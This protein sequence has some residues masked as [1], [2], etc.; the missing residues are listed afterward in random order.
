MI[1]YLIQLFSCCFIDQFH[2]DS[3]LPIRK[4]FSVLLL[5]VLKNC[6][7]KPSPDKYRNVFAAQHSTLDWHFSVGSANCSIFHVSISRNRFSS[8]HDVIALLVCT[9]RFSRKEQ[10]VESWEMGKK[11]LVDWFAVVEA[12]C[13]L[14]TERKTFSSNFGF[15][16]QMRLHSSCQTFGGQTLSATTTLNI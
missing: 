13:W 16:V 2:V 11:K 12:R 7:K 3:L 1:V 6:I 10:T 5:L 14:T 15:I 9:G 8:S 4:T